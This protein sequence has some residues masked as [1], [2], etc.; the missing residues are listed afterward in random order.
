MQRFEPWR[1]RAVQFAQHHGAAIAE[2]DLAW[3]H[4]IRAEVDE[5]ADCAITAD[6]ALDDQFVEAVLQRQHIA[7]LCQMRC[8]GACGRL[9]VLRLH[10][11]EDALPGAAHFIWRERGRG[12]G[13]LLHRAGDA[14][15]VGA[16]CRDMLG[17][18]VDKRDVV[19]GAFQ[20]RAH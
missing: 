3:C 14:Q 10:R 17:H 13:E 16:N 18:D 4:P 8:Q 11:E 6:D 19:A 12:N 7:V 9:G 2:H 5:R 15:S 20:P 1:H